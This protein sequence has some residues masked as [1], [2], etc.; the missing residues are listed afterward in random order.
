MAEYHQYVFDKEKREFIGDFEEMYRQ[1]SISNFDSWHQEDSRQLKLN[2]VLS[3]IN[4]MNYS[5]I[6]DIGCGKGSF[7]HKLKKRNNFVYGL[8]VSKTA[9]E[10]AQQRFPDIE[11][12]SLDVNDISEVLKMF[13]GV[14]KGKGNIDLVFSSECF[15]YL[16]NWE[17]LIE[18]ISEHTKYFIISLYIPENPIVFINSISELEEVVSKFFYINESIHLTKTNSYIVLSKSKKM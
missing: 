9:V 7:S 17:E 11:F 16:K 3:L 4:E 10:I 2:I 15:S 18:T 6:I 5:T 8:D 13:K 12:S 14:K 1:E